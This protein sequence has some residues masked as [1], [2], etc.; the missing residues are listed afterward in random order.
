M[1]NV[2]RSNLAARSVNCCR[3]S[4]A[5]PLSESLVLRCGRGTVA[6][7]GKMIRYAAGSASRAG[8]LPGRGFRS[9]RPQRKKRLRPGRAAAKAVAFSPDETAINFL[10][11]TRVRYLRNDCRGRLLC[12][13]RCPGR[14]FSRVDR[15][16]RF[17]S[18]YFCTFSPERQN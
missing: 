13:S 6:P 4:S 15:G 5:S 11:V 10:Y 18:L 16:L 2:V 12:V 14:N 17:L 1:R 3:E 8:L 7:N 9:S